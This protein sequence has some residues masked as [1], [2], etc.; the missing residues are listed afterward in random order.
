VVVLTPT[1]VPPARALAEITADTLRQV[2]MKVQAPAM[3]WAT[4]L[5]RRASTEPVSQGGWS[6]FHTSWSGLD[7]VNPA[8][9]L[10]LRG[11][12]R[13]AAPGL[14][15]SPRIEDLRDAWFS[16]PELPAQQALARLLQLQAFTDVPYIPLGQY[17]APTAYRANLTGVLKGNPVFWNLRRT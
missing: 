10:F 16:A 8:A 12:G 14:P 17:S 15:D 1:D 4:L 3:D 7:M 11:D 13:A 5:R 2:G 6:I 9:H